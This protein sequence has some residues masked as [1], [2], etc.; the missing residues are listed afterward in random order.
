MAD[1]K[2]V[3]LRTGMEALYFSGAYQFLR[4][5]LGGVGAILTLHHVRPPRPDAFQ[6][7]RL[8]EVSPEFLDDVLRDLRHARVDLVTLDEMHRRLVERDFRRRFICLTFDDGYRD[9]LR[10]ALPILKAHDAPFAL[11]IP[12]SFP[13][14]QGELWW[15]ILEAVIARHTRIALRMDG[16]DRRYDCDGTDA[17][18]ELYEHI[19]WWLRSLD[20]EEELRA[21]VRDLA[22]RY[23][24]D[25][26]ALCKDLC[27]TWEEIGEIAADPL[28]TIGAHTVNHVMLQ[29]VGDDAVRREMQQ[30]ASVIETTLGKRPTHFSYPVGDRTS[31]GPREFRIAAE[32]GLQD[33]GDHAS[34]RALPGAL[35]VP[36]RAAADFAQRR[37]PAAAL[38]Q[39]SGIRH[40]HRAVEQI[41]PGGCRLAPVGPHHPRDER[42][43]WQNPAEPRHHIEQRCDPCVRRTQ[44]EL[45]ERHREQ[46][47]HRDEHEQR[48]GSNELARANRHDLLLVRV[49]RLTACRRSIWSAPVSG[50]MRMSTLQPA[51]HRHRAIRLWLYAVAVLIFA[52]VLVGGATRLTESGLSIVEWKPVTGAL[53]PMSETAWQAEFDKYKTI[54]QFQHLNSAMTLHEFKTIF[55]WEWTHRLMGRLIGAAF[56]LPFLWFLA[57]GWIGQGLRWRLWAIFGLGAL[58]GAVG[59]WMVASGLAD[60]VEVSQY[61]LA[62]H[63]I[64]AVFIF[65]AILWTA[66][67]LGGRA[68]IE[69]PSRIR[70]TALALL[71]LALVQIYL[72]ALV[73]GLRAGL[74]YNTWPLIDG[75]LIPDAARL[76][77]DTPLWRNFFENT[78]TVQ[79]T[80]RMVAYAL[81]LAALLHAIDVLRALRR[82]PAVTH[83]LTLAGLVTIQAGLGILTLLQQVPIGLALAHQ[84][85]AVL[86][87]ALATIHAQA[88]SVRRAEQPLGAPVEA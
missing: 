43:R 77:H 23:G 79:F 33:R 10:Y 42:H 57:K 69:A 53:P 4:P 88:L 72:G 9:N 76:F 31:A 15:L 5:L 55:W 61:R 18:Y 27:M 35:G 44:R 68:A 47:P 12:T 29:K 87:L 59:W 30:S 78:L 13:D 54:P 22:G 86:V 3:V 8:L 51:E 62:T 46:R 64:L 71:A 19:Y 28:A 45:C 24:V 52:M 56:L 21:V 85:G 66:A 32:L 37:I 70:K 74:I 82:G 67:R 75:G 65:A 39:G 63:L 50:N 6:P 36:D 48:D 2:R 41:S 40:R 80:H 11:Y 1:L 34:G 58:Q 20:T 26:A 7:N 60:R 17:K 38:R 14:R 25:D 16:Q 84:A 73:A 83:A 49:R 81:W